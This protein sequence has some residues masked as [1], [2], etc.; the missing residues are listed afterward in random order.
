[1]KDNK[2]ARLLACA[3]GLVNRESLPRNEYLAG[4][5]R[6]LRARLPVRLRLSDPEKI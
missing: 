4:G 1:M 6:I 2:R 3:T 5:N